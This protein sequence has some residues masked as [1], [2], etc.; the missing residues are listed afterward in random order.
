MIILTTYPPQITFGNILI[1]VIFWATIIAL[2][3][4]RNKTPQ[5]KKMW[6]G[7]QIF[8]AVLL[9]TLGANYAKKSIKDWWSK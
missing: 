6:R 2:Y 5:N 9:V 4:S 7:V 1:N 3:R 8:F